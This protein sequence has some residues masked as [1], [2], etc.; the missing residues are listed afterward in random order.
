MAATF[1]EALK[2][3]RKL[4]EQDIT[5]AECQE[6]LDECDNDW[7]YATPYARAEVSKLP[8]ESKTEFKA[9]MKAAAQANKLKKDKAKLDFEKKGN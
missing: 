4:P 9:K 5:I 1:E 6:A 3:F 8:S 2:L 7:E